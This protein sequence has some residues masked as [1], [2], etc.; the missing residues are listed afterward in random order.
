MN[1]L[2]TIRQTI[3]EI[4]RQMAALFEARMQAVGRVAF[5]KK[6]NGLPILDEGR[7]TQVIEKNRALIREPALRDDYEEYIRF[8]MA[9][10]RRYQAR[11]LGQ[12]S[13]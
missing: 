5:Y 13:D 2:E 12:T 11:L 1:E 3:D 4:D 9:L 7:E 8:Q 10:S 6:E